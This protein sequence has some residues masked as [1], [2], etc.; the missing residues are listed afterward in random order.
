MAVGTGH[1]TGVIYA[2]NFAHY[3]ILASLRSSGTSVT[4]VQMNVGH[5]TE[6]GS[7]ISPPPPAPFT[8]I[9]F[10]DGGAELIVRITPL[11]NSNWSG[12][13]RL[14]GAPPFP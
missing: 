12:Y 13:V 5:T 4:L 1:D 11:S 14:V 2:E 10:V 3:D 8:V 9:T 6:V 7:M